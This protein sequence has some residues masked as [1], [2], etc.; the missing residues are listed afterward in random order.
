MTENPRLSPRRQIRTSQA[1]VASLETERTDEE[2]GQGDVQLE[3]IE[4]SDGTVGWN[5]VRS[6]DGTLLGDIIRITR[7]RPGGRGR[8][9]YY[10]KKA[11]L[12]FGE[13]FRAKGRAVEYVTSR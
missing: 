3:R 4:V 7:I 13:E 12:Y 9:S 2:S 10:A 8:F 11:S 5:V 6:P 1:S